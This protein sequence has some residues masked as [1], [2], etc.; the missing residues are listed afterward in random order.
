VEFKK[1]LVP[2]PM[3]GHNLTLSYNSWKLSVKR[4]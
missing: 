2:K 4:L 1:V 3:H